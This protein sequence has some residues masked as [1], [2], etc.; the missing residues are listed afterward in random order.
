MCAISRDYSSAHKF[1]AS[2]WS[3]SNTQIAFEIYTFM[4]EPG[5]NRNCDLQRASTEDNTHP[6]LLPGL[7]QERRSRIG[8]LVQLKLLVKFGVNHRYVSG[9][10]F[11]HEL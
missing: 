10:F 4:F 5:E 9:C 7:I 2:R 3:S 11:G 8:W 1:T 6:N